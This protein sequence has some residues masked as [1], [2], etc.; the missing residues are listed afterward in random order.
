MRINKE[1]WSWIFYDWANSA[2]GIIVTTAVL[3]VYFKSI[4]QTQHVSAASSTAI[5]GYANS[6][7][8]LLVSLLAPILGALA[9]YPHFKKKM[10]NIFC[11]LGIVMTFALAIVPADQWQLLLV[12]YIF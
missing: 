1:Q 4:A 3:P 7:S 9:D 8:T 5:W 6:F 12:I 11:W 2:Y 10:L